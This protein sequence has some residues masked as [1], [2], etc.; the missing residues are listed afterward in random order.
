MAI[1]QMMYNEPRLYDCLLAI[2]N[3]GLQDR[4]AYLLC[5]LNNSYVTQPSRAPKVVAAL[6]ETSKKKT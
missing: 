5:N 4:V 1:A 6:Q 2:I 3:G